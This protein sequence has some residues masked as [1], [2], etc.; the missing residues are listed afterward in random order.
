MLLKLLQ[1]LEHPLQSKLLT[2]LERREIMRV[3][4][5][6]NIPIDV[7]MICA[8]NNNIHQDVAEGV[9]RQDLLYRINTVEIHLPGLRDRTGDIPLLADHFLKIYSRKYRKCGKNICPKK[10]DLERY[11]STG[12]SASWT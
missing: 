1:F 9:F 12:R 3:G 4:S 5:T 7:R 8:T 10:I 11:N 2:V 6:K